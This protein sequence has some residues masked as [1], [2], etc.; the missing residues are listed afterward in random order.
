M[1]VLFPPSHLAKQALQALQQFGAL[2]GNVGLLVGALAQVVELRGGAVARFNLWPPGNHG[3][4]VGGRDV[5]VVLCAQR[6]TAVAG[7]A[8]GI[9]ARTGVATQ[10][11]GDVVLAVV[12]LGGLECDI[13]Q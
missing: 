5:F 9:I 7:H 12:C 8:Y 1:R 2:L 11:G 4:A 10:P 3:T 13:G 6:Q